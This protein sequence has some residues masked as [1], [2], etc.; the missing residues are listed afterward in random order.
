MILSPEDVRRN[1]PD[2]L[3]L[4]ELKSQR[5]FDIFRTIYDHSFRIGDSAAGWE[6]RYATEFHMTNDSKYFP[7]LGNW[8]SKGYKPD[9]FGRWIGSGGKVALPLYQGTLVHQFD[10]SYRSY[11]SGAGRNAKYLAEP[12]DRKQIVPQFLMASDIATNRILTRL[13]VAFRAIA[14]ATDTRS[15]ISSVITD[16]ACSG[17]VPVL[18]VNCGDVLG[19]C[20]L[21]GILNSLTFDSVLRVRLVSAKISR[22][23]LDE[24][25]LPEGL[26]RCHPRLP[27]NAAA[28]T[29][30]H[31]RFAPE[32]LKIKSHVPGA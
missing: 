9:V 5:D 32:W 8:Q 13:R 11:T 4:V 29:F 30:I 6:I 7:A 26:G 23:V 14:R 18:S 22:F 20:T 31:R 2:S 12:T 25:P 15:M 17:M 1:S 21:S 10:P 16:Y 28:L 19:S 27:R 24:C 3:C